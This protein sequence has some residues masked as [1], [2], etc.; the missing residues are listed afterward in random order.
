MGLESSPQHIDDLDESWP[1]TGDNTNEGDDHIRNLKNVLKV[2]FPGSGG[3]GFNTP[4]T[5]NEAEINTLDG[6]TS[7]TAELNKLDGVTVGVTEFNHLSGLTENVQTA[8]DGSVNS[9]SIDS[10]DAA[11]EVINDGETITVAGG[12]GITTSRV[13]N[14]IS[15]EVDQA[16]E[17]TIGGGEIAT[18]AEIDTGTDDARIVTPAK[19]VHVLDGSSTQKVV[20]AAIAYTPHAVGDF[21]VHEQ[22]LDNPNYSSSLAKRFG[23]TMQVAGT[24]RCK[25]SNK[26]YHNTTSWITLT[27]YKN[28][29]T[30]GITLTNYQINDHV[31]SVEGSVT[32]AAGDTCEVW[33]NESF[34]DPTTTSDMLAIGIADPNGGVLY[35]LLSVSN[36]NLDDLEA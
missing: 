29:V 1:L 2:V 25:I 8:L 17:G 5:A 18:T 19:L 9:F 14:V 10:D 23:C 21:V 16:L 31:S 7:T 36:E 12:D 28:G 26:H 27:I 4:I 3:L 13:G 32:F 30:T 24:Y 15:A 20:G 35:N 22:R 6:L 11:P 33:G 34:N